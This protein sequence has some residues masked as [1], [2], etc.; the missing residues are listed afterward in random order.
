MDS[1]RSKETPVFQTR[2]GTIGRKIPDPTPR[3]F[4]HTED[5]GIKD[6]LT[7]LHMLK[8]SFI[9]Y[10]TTRAYRTFKQM[11]KSYEILTNVVYKMPIVVGD[12]ERNF[13]YTNSLTL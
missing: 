10:K 13:P 5:R 12:R 2:S 1:V 7:N 8:P 6:I 3:Y 9:R 11:M 4:L